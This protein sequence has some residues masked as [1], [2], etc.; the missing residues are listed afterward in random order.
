MLSYGYRGPPQPCSPTWRSLTW[1]V[2]NPGGFFC[3]GQKSVPLHAFLTYFPPRN[4]NK[5]RAV[6][7]LAR[8]ICFLIYMIMISNC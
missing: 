2:V 5:A 7:P 3:V 1:Q 6:S 4:N 8:K